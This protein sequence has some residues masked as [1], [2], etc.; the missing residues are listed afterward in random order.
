[1]TSR[2][3]VAT[4]LA[5]LAL[6]LAGCG[7]EPLYA[8]RPSGPAA[9]SLRAIRVA[10]ISERIGQRLEW[11]LRTDLNPSGIPT[12]QK[13]ELSTSLALQRASLGIQSTGLATLGRL[14]T[15]ATI[16]LVDLKTGKELLTNTIHS[17]TA[18]N[19]VD[20]G[21]ATVVAE[22][23]ADRRTVEDLSREIVIRLTQ[24]MQRLAERHPAVSLRKGP[25]L[26]ASAQ[27]DPW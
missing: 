20:N 4:L 8:D 14:D 16:R 1:M 12:P 24:F 27:T 6:A 10:P 3:A 2:R 26:A 13:Y 9:A 25:A 17:Q 18:F 11:A 22:T 23:D 7:W 5:A 15:F 21:Y 19:I